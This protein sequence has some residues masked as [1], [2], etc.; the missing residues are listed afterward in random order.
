MLVFNYAVRKRS[1]EEQRRLNQVISFRRN[2][3]REKL[4]RLELKLQEVLE[5]KD[6]SRFKEGYIMNRIASK[7]AYEEDQ[8]IQE[9]AAT[10]AAKDA[11]KKSKK[12]LEEKKNQAA[13]AGP[14]AAATTGKRQPTLKITKGKLG[15][16]TKKADGAD[17]SKNAAVKM[18]QR[19]IKGMEEMYWSVRYQLDSLDELRKR[20]DQP[21]IWDL[22]YEAYDLY[23]NP[24]K[25]MQIE[26]LREVVFELKRDF[27]KEF[28]ALERYKED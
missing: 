21:N 22:I 3:L 9:A 24:R 26:L 12:A 14:G 16:K 2:E 13:G 20:L 15:A 17:D 6:F 10:F 1:A 4:R 8:S 18:Q 25:R 28:D 5:E 19:D 27:N 23:S 7:P 11:E